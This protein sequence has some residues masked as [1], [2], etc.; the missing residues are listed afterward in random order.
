MIFHSRMVT[1]K[2][3]GFSDITVAFHGIHI[4]TRARSHTKYILIN[5]LLRHLTESSQTISKEI[6][7]IIVKNLTKLTEASISFFSKQ[8]KNNNQQPYIYQSLGMDNF[9]GSNVGY[10]SN[11]SVAL[12]VYCLNMYT[13]SQECHSGGH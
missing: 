3:P 1:R 4:Q 6:K 12:V 13:Y 10:G 5:T 7:F 9:S 11:V 8:K 2:G